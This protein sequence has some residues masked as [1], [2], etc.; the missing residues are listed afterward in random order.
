M[1]NS[2]A[3]T[4]PAYAIETLRTGV[5]RLARPIRCLGFWLSIALPLVYLPLLAGGLTGSQT[6]TFPA[7]LGLHLLALYVGHDYA[8]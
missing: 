8:R 6:V 5:E 1:S 7:L 2:N 3:R 4:P